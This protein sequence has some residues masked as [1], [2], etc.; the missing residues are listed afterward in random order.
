MTSSPPEPDP[1]AKL[2]A[3]EQVK[4]LATC[5]NTLATASIAIGVFGPL[6][7]SLYGVPGAPTPAPSLAIIAGGWVSAGI[8]L[9]LA[10]RYI[11]KGLKP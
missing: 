9:H 3:N 11:L 8:L 6:A 4:L 5:L 7:A 10:G 1:G 2:I